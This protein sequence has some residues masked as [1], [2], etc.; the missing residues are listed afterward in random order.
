[1]AVHI[2]HHGWCFDGAASAAL[3][4]AFLRRRGDAGPI[5][6]IPKDHRPGDP[7]DPED[8]AADVVASVDFRYSQHPRLTWF[9]DHHHSAF[10]L[11]GDREHFL[12][13]TSGRKFHDSAATS[14]AGYIAR[15]VRDRFACDLAAHAELIRWAEVI[16]AAAFPDPRMPVDLDEPALLLM[17]FVESNQDLALVGPFIDDLLARP[18]AE[19]AGADY[20]QR[21][22]RPRLQQNREDIALIARRA[23]LDG[24]VLHYDLLDQPAR[25]Y[26]KFIPYYHHPRVRYVVAL[27]R[28]TDRRIKLTA[29][30]NPWLPRDAREHSMAALLE[31]HGG[32]GHPYVAGCSFPADHEDR[33]HAV[34][35]DLT[36][37]LRGPGAARV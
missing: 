26:N 7:Y 8:F 10:Q 14:C 25:A 6:Y 35:R 28:A 33:A 2:L 9:F 11:P 18:L 29:G 5:R 17:A 31:P 4:A 36:R 34:L 19:L 20:V 16:D 32:G 1:M 24:D 22:V 3:F 21:V 30:Y 27:T 37:V 12:A 15:I 13:D 23:V